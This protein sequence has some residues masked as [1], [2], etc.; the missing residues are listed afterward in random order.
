MFAKLALCLMM[1]AVATLAKTAHKVVLPAP[2][3]PLRKTGLH[4][5]IQN[6]SKAWVR[7]NCNAATDLKAYQKC[8]QYDVTCNKA[9]EATTGGRVLICDSN[10][11]PMGCKADSKPD[12]CFIPN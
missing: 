7:V 1:L 6:D 2:T 4:V 12:G 11:K 10:K 9:G 5:T 3:G 8:Y